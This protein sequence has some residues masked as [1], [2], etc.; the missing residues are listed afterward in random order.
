MAME[1]LKKL[2]WQLLIILIALIV[3]ASILWGQQAEPVIVES[4]EP[5]GGGVYQ[6]GIVGSFKRLNPLLARYN[7][8]DQ[9]VTSLIFTGLV[10]HD[11]KGYPQPDLA[12]SWGI[13]KNGEIYNFSLRTDATWHDGQ[14]VTSEDVAFTVSL[15]KDEEFPTPQDVESFWE[16]IEVE[17]LDEHTLQFR[18]PEPF[19]PFLNYLD[20]GI[21]PAHILGDLS[22]SEIIDADFNLNPIGTGPYQFDRFLGEND[23]ISGVVLKRYGDYYQDQAYLEE[24]VFLYFD[25]HQEVWEAYENGDILGIGEVTEEIFPSAL[26]APDLNLYTSRL[27]EMSIILLN[28]DNPEVSFFQDVELRQAMLQG[29]NRQWMVDH[30]LNGQAVIADG[31]IFPKTW[32]YYDGLKHY[33]Y[34]P[35]KAINALRDLGYTIPAEGGDIRVNE[36]EVRLEFTLLYPDDPEH[37][38]LAEAIQED[39]MGLG[40]GVA[41]QALSYEELKTDYLAPRIYEAAL[42]DFNLSHNPDPDP[43]PFWH[44]TQTTGGQNYSMW[45]DRQASEY[46]EQARIVFN[47]PEERARLYRNFQVRFVDQMPALPLFYPMYTYGV[48]QEVKGVRIG[49]IFKP[50]DRFETVT[51]WYFYSEVPGGQVPPETPVE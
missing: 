35:E 14:P 1:L 49:P 15:L 42:I 13:S 16:D 30:I 23:Q 20:F 44:Q 36:E 8:A 43:Y 26:E 41:L 50:S 34:E 38:A 28:L 5:T 47:N 51:D 46:I 9:D 2:R 33:E 21:L 29:L 10:Q 17:A 37:Q 45:N 39:W 6:E 11:S 48:S 7:P 32:A 12:N 25:S 22:P 4:P 40:F 31:P 27:P 24:S 3:I 19:A 18:L